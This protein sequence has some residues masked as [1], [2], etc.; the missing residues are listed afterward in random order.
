MMLTH[1]V[2]LEFIILKC[3][4]K[5]S[6]EPFLILYLVM[7]F[8]FFSPFS[9]SLCAR[10][11]SLV[12]FSLF[13]QTYSQY[14]LIRTFSLNKYLLLRE[15]TEKD[16]FFIVCCEQMI[17]T[18]LYYF[19]LFFVFDRMIYR[20]IFENVAFDW[21]SQHRQWKMSLLHTHILLSH[22]F[23]CSFHCSKRFD[24]YCYEMVDVNENIKNYKCNRQWLLQFG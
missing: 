14:N 13:G 10:A 2:S 11:H 23:R 18:F 3:I 19:S 12:P 7:L 20:Q 9:S 8:S 1:Y 24:C 15:I 4:E 21:I 5:R 17:S 16:F 22:S 6:L